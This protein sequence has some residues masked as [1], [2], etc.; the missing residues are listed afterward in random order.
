MPH[1]FDI[2]F[3]PVANDT[4][5]QT[6]VLFETGILTKPETI[7][8]LKVHRL[9]DQYSFNT[10]SSLACLCFANAYEVPENPFV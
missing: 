2:V 5:Y 9:F 10:S 6:L 1:G 8:R 7:S 3:G 4:L